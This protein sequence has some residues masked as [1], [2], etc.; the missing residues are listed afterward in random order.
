[1]GT[2]EILHEG[3]GE[4][5]EHCDVYVAT[6]GSPQF[7]FPLPFLEEHT[8]HWITT[9]PPPS[10]AGRL[11]YMNI[12]S[13]QLQISIPPQTALNTIHALAPCFKRSSPFSSSLG[14]L[15]SHHH[16]QSSTN[17]NFAIPPPLPPSPFLFDPIF[18]LI[19]PAPLFS[20]PS[21]SALTT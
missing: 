10:Q 21:S 2:P 20:A 16:H 12:Y 19:S 1:M 8:S 17:R 3:G 9:R 18:H 11:A 13:Q 7:C 5:R 15:I 4:T 14:D 6:L